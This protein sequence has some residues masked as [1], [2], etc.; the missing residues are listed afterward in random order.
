M[1]V[2]VFGD[3]PKGLVAFNESA[4]SGDFRLRDHAGK[5]AVFTVLGPKQIQT[6]FGDKTAVSANVTVIESD[7][8]TTDYSD[9]LIFNKAPVDQ[10]QGSTGQRVVAAI[11]LYDTKR[12]EYDGT[13][14]MAPRLVAPTAEQ[15]AAAEKAIG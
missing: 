11:E 15:L 2:S 3:Q 14:K 5:A 1:S 8:S 6:E 10:L 7:G 13:A 4:G 9:A 12:K